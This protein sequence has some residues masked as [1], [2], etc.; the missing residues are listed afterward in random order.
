[1]DRPRA[2]Q[3]S[4]LLL[5]SL[6]AGCGASDG[7]EAAGA[8]PGPGARDAAERVRVGAQ[9][10]L[11][12]SLDLVRGR[13][14]GLVTNHTGIV[15]TAD[16]DVR[17]TI[18]LLYRHPEVELVA[19]YGPEH[20]IRGTAEA[21]EL[22]DSSTDAATGLP[23]HSLYGGTR[24]PT[25]EM[26]DGVE[27]LLFDIQDVGARYYTYLWTMTLVMEATAEAGIPFVVLDRPNPIGGDLVQ[28]N[29]L[30]TAFATFVGLFPVPMRHGLTPGEMARLVAGEFGVGDRASL[31]VIPLEGWE[32]E[33]EF[34][35]TGLPWVAPSPNMPDEVSALHY[36]GTCL[37]EG[38]VLSVGRGT[39]R[40]FQQIGAPWLDGDALASA[41]EGYALPGV[42]FESVTF[43]PRS[44]GDGKFPETEVRGVRFRAVGAG[45]DPTRAAVAALLE[46]RRQAGERWEWREAHFDRLAGTDALRRAVEAGATLEEAVAGWEAQAAAFRDLRRPYLLY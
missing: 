9:R 21:G 4:L 2:R 34:V 37:F 30:D 17:S 22:V 33:M 45:Y 16:G 11:E 39:D 38:T 3:S 19:L 6:A 5:L 32:R 44:P 14:V 18:D 20:G 36:P 40:A 46:A 29:V 8:V 23:I 12:D 28:G 26:L 41:L 7:G 13:R 42:A 35:E 15:R 24:K 31:S 10:L 25:A 27:V 43:T 1:M